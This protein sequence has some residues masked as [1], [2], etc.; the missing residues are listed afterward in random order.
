LIFIY[1]VHLRIFSN[2]LF[3][4]ANVHVNFRHV[5]SN[6][7]NS[8]IPSFDLSSNVA[9]SSPV[10]L[11]SSVLLLPLSSFLRNFFSPGPRV[12]RSSLLPSFEFS[13]AASE[14][15]DPLPPFP[16]NSLSPRPR[17]T[18]HPWQ[19][20]LP[21]PFRRRS[22]SLVRAARRSG[23]LDFPESEQRLRRASFCVGW[24]LPSFRVRV[25]SATTLTRSDAVDADA[26]RWFFLG[27]LRFKFPRLNDPSTLTTRRCFCGVVYRFPFF[28]FERRAVDRAAAMFCGVV[29]TSYVHQVRP[30]YTDDPPR[31]SFFLVGHTS[32]ATD[33]LHPSKKF[34]KFNG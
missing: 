20:A 14:F 9:S 27:Y 16:K 30:T 31:C 11:P 22:G 26:L 15:R 17:P 4:N 23:F 21:F 19:Q 5:D 32:S 28:E 25:P 29:Y 1:N 33:T 34:K 10:P 13:F 3:S 18:R 12:L 6:F 8:M 24:V 7:A 2:R